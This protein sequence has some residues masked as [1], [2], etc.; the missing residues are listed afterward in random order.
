M[1]GELLDAVREGRMVGT[2]SLSTAP[3]DAP[4]LVPAGAIAQIILALDGD[5]LVA[6][7]GD[8]PGGRADNLGCLPLAYRKLVPGE[9]IRLASG[10]E[11][12]AAFNGACRDWKVL[13]A[14]Q[15]VGLSSAALDLGVDYA[16]SRE[17]FGAAI[18][19]F[20]T[21][22]HRLADDAT[23]IDGARL[24]AYKA[25]WAADEGR[26]GA[27]ALASMAWSFSSE[28]ALGVTRDSLHYHGGYG[29]TREYDIQLYFRRAKAYPLVWGDPRAE[30]QRLADELFG[31][32]GTST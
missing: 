30:Y 14:A 7:V 20:Q 26:S 17:V 21:I 9:R 5:D 3:A 12:A 18:A 22:A 25:A 4:R 29:F 28:T 16:K 2:V 32:G 19:T 24:L 8:P 11:A 13:S 27:G 15:L 6:V 1:T 31:E 23:A 10:P